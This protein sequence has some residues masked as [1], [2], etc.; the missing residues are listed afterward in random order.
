MRLPLACFLS[1][2]G[3]VQVTVLFSP[4][5]HCVQLLLLPAQSCALG[6]Y[7][8]ALGSFSTSRNGTTDTVVVGVAHQVDPGSYL[9]RSHHCKSHQLQDRRLAQKPKESS[10]QEKNKVISF[11]V[12]WRS[13]LSH[14]CL[15]SSPR[16]HH[17]C[18]F[19]GSVH[20]WLLPGYQAGPVSVSGEGPCP[21]Q[22]SECPLRP[23][24]MYRSS[25][26]H[27]AGLYQVFS[28]SC[29]WVNAKA[30]VTCLL[31]TGPATSPG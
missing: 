12:T 22:P 18:L 19:S 5:L 30:K 6:L 14:S 16:S 7:A 31:R 17:F 11:G 27:S 23:P 25:Y 3:S 1:L 13:G 8:L 2:L 15:L 21:S 10:K 24:P 26:V 4:G 20:S 28:R 9:K 29:S